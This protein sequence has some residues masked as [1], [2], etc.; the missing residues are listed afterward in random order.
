MFQTPYPV[1][2]CFGLMVAALYAKGW[3]I[4]WPTVGEYRKMSLEPAGFHSRDRL[5]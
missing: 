1:C 3:D 5:H 2:E 4:G